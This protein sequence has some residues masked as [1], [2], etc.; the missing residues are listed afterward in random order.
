[1]GADE[2]CQQAASDAGLA[3]TFMAWLSDQSMGPSARM[4]HGK[5]HYALTTGEVIATG[6][7][8]LTD[9]SLLHAIDRDQKG[10]VSA[11]TFVCQGGEVWTNTTVNG[12]PASSADCSGWTSHLPTSSA[13]NVMFSDPS[14]TS[15]GCTAIACSSPLPLYCFE[16]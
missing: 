14:W 1:M 13:G 6:W 7:A 3:G 12:S 5:G 10:N 9:G 2:K 8:D 4:V 16:Q 15:S 11:G